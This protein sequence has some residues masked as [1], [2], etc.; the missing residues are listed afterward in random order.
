[1]TSYIDSGIQLTNIK[2]LIK[3]NINNEEIFWIEFK[4]IWKIF[5][6]ELN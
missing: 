3:S 5:W 4:R 6:I 1:M 2:E